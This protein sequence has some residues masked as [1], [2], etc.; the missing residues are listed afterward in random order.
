MWVLLCVGVFGVGALAAYV[1]FGGADKVSAEDRG[2][3]AQG[4][5]KHESRS[6]TVLKPHYNDDQLV[7]DKTEKASPEGKDPMVFAVNEFLAQSKVA[8]E[9]ARAQTCAIKDGVATI[10]F[11]KEFDRTYGTEDEHTIVEGILRTMGQFPEIQSVQFNVNGQPLETL[12]NID[13]TT[14]QPV[15]RPEPNPHP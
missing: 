15:L 12:G 11:S 10:E 6:V 2:V 14:P 4:A 8:P 9:A 1:K 3:A 13:L 7:F 5:T